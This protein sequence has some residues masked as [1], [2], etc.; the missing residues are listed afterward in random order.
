MKKI[1]LS[2]I[3][4]LSIVLFSGC[5]QQNVEKENASLMADSSEGSQETAEEGDKEAK[6]PIAESMTNTEVSGNGNSGETVYTREEE[7][8][9]SDDSEENSEEKVKDIYVGEYND[10]DANQP[11]LQIQKNEDGTYTIQVGV[12]RLTWVEGKGTLTENGIEFTAI[13]GKGKELT[14][15][16]V[17]EEDIAVVTFDKEVWAMYSHINE[18][19]YYKTSDVP[20]LWLPN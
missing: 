9:W 19:R 1:L 7:S 10:Y 20:N 11:E 15:T 8:S 17:L 3:L 6:V 14:G 2:F 5:G 13:V 12:F 16:I 4:C 18:Y